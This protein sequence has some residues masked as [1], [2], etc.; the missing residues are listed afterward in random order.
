M[1]SYVK[2]YLEKNRI[3]YIVH[4]HEPIFTAEASIRACKNIPGLHCKNLFIYDKKKDQYY[5]FTTPAL[6]RVDLKTLGLK[7]G[8]KHLSLG[9]PE[10]LQTYLKIAPGHVSPLCLLNDPEKKVIFLINK[11]VW[12]AEIVGFHPNENDKTLEIAQEA[13][14]RLVESFGQEKHIVDMT[15]Q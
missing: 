3:E 8:V 9:S 1:L 15:P 11:V 13:F 10:A 5:L 4:S 12:E 2:D 7:I 6:E 14:H